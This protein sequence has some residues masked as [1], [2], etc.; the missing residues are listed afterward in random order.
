MKKFVFAVSAVSLLAA[1]SVIVPTA[2]MAG[3]APAKTSNSTQ[4]SASVTT[5]S[6]PPTYCNPNDPSGCG[7][8]D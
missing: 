6:I 1:A 2:V 7:I 5:A 4:A 8:F 3:S